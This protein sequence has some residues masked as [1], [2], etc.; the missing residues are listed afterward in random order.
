MQVC[1]F[2][3]L[4]C[5]A[6]LQSLRVHPLKSSELIPY[7]LIAC[8]LQPECF[9]VGCLLPGWNDILPSLLWVLSDPGVSGNHAKSMQIQMSFQYPKK[10]KKVTPRSP[11]GVKMTP[12]TTSPTPNH[13]IGDKSEII[14]KVLCLPWFKHIQP[15]HAGIMDHQKNGPGNCLPL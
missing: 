11:N 10:P 13:C 8:I 2:T 6:I 4:Q 9:K 15:L 7:S 12:K 14:Q 5:Y 3:A 1:G